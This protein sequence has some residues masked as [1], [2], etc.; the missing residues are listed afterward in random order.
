[1]AGGDDNSL[2][3]DS[4]GKSAGFSFPRGMTLDPDGVMYLT[5]SYPGT[6]RKV[7]VQ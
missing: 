7:V 2:S 4:V 6:I 5:N 1:M 3:V